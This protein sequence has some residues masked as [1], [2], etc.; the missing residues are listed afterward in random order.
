MY[1]QDIYQVL[2]M[3]QCADIIISQ[4]HICWKQ[5]TGQNSDRTLSC[6]GLTESSRTH[7]SSAS[8]GLGRTVM[9]HRN[10]RSSPTTHFLKHSGQVHVSSTAYSMTPL[11]YGAQLM[12]EGENEH[13]EE[14]WQLLSGWPFTAQC[15]EDSLATLKVLLHRENQKKVWECR[16]KLRRV[17]AYRLA[18]SAVHLCQPSPGCAII[19]VQTLQALHPAE[20]PPTPR[21]PCMQGF[22]GAG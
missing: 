6:S 4:I 3:Y 20:P 13:A 21:G 18:H 5:E 10:C 16:R 8:S 22:Y 11:L 1:W 9:E 14:S 15:D 17:I 19:L 7:S 12:G 2:Y